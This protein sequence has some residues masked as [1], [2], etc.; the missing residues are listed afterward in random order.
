[1]SRSLVLLSV[2]AMLAFTFGLSGCDAP[3]DTA[4][5]E[6]GADDD[7]HADHDHGDD[8]DHDHGDDADHDHGDDADHDHGDDADH[9]HPDDADHDHGD[10]ADHDHDDAAADHGDDDHDHDA[11]A[12][13]MQGDAD[14][15]KIEAAFAQLSADDQTAARAQKTCPV[16]DELL[17]EMGTPYKAT[18]NGKDVFLCCESCVAAAKADPAKYGL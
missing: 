8:A 17:G 3:Q 10:D 13:Q 7:D 12:G 14:N 2:L 11:H 1:M 9:D 16:S 18:I 4:P 5:A 15:S 6:Q